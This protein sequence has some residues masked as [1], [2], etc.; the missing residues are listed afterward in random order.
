MLQWH[1]NNTMVETIAKIFHNQH[2][3]WSSDTAAGTLWLCCI[4]ERN[5]KEGISDTNSTKLFSKEQQSFCL[6]LSP[7]FGW[8]SDCRFRITVWYSYGWSCSFEIAWNGLVYGCKTQIHASPHPFKTYNDTSVHT[9]THMHAHALTYTKLTP[10][11]HTHLQHSNIHCTCLLHWWEL[12]H[13]FWRNKSILA[14]TTLSPQQNCLSWQNIFVATKT[15]AM[16]KLSSWQAYSCCN[17]RHV[18]LR[19][20][21]FVVTKVNLS[22]QKLYLLRQKHVCRDKSSVTTNTLL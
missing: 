16:T 20:H 12:P 14:T 7:G 9:H 2:C 4:S 21:V 13:I 6:F 18:L 11:T 3:T 15:F 8:T 17:K 5:Q 19:Q 22:Q 10:H 1:Q